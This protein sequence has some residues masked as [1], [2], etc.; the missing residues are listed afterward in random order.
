MAEVDPRGRRDQVLPR[1]LVDR[2]V[3][4]VRVEVPDGVDVCGDV[5]GA[6]EAANRVAGERRVRRQPLAADLLVRQVIP[7]RDLHVPRVDR[8]HLA[9]LTRELEQADAPAEQ[10][11]LDLVAVVA[12]PRDAVCGAHRTCRVG[13]CW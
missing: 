4:P 13:M 5:L 9:H 8:H 3:W 10:V 7:E 6:D 2:Q 1:Q 12:R 11:E